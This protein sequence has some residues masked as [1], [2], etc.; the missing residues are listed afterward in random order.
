MY[1]V[2]QALKSN[3]SF[4]VPGEEGERLPSTSAPSQQHSWRGS[5]PPGKK[6]A[7]IA[8]CKRPL[9]NKAVKRQG[10]PGAR[11][12]HTPCTVYIPLARPRYRW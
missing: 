4:T 9:F 2:K 6:E 10:L 12:R 3:P 1:V 5:C 8:Q 11:P 7:A